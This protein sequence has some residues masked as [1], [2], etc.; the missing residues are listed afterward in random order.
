MPPSPP[1]RIHVQ[2]VSARL[3][4]AVRAL[5]VD[6][7]QYAFVG[8]VQANLIHAEAC[9]DSEPMAILEGGDAGDAEVV[10]YYRIDLRPGDIVGCEAEGRCAALRS[11]MIDRRHQGRGLGTLALLACRDD[12]RRRHPELATLALTVNC[13]NARALGAYRSVG[14]IDTGRL[15]FG[16]T[17]GPQHLLVLRL[18][19]DDVGK[20]AA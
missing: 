18:H 1:P 5:R 10:G 13:S 17:A 8:D 3:A 2:P 16:G 14:F 12:L 9:P 4:A 11:L 7:A 15:Q 6:P 19:G 20:S